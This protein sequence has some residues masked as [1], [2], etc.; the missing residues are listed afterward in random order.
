MGGVGGVLHDTICFAGAWCKE[1][2][3]DGG[4]SWLGLVMVLFLYSMV[5]NLG[6]EIYL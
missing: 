2:V 4:E 1:N 6:Q 5:F 3:Q